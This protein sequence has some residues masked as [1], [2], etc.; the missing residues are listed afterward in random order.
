MSL[1]N[2]DEFKGTRSH[3]I[4]TAVLSFLRQTCWNL[5]FKNQTPATFEHY[6]HHPLLMWTD[7]FK[8]LHWRLN[9]MITQVYQ[10]WN[11]LPYHLIF[12]NFDNSHKVIGSI[13]F[14]RFVCFII[15]IYFELIAWSTSF[16]TPAQRRNT[17]IYKAFTRKSL[18]AE[19]KKQVK[20]RKK[21]NLA[22]KQNKTFA[23][24]KK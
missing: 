3:D 23:T 18:S 5:N 22:F 24:C 19:T 13:L 14:V 9:N 21:Y 10:V 11:L 16:K 8:L 2:K 12:C 4:K 17:N 1:S 15:S 6:K 7:S 20:A